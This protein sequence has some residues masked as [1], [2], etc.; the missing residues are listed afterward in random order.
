[1]TPG[2][3]CPWVVNVF[4]LSSLSDAWR[5]LGWGN[6]E[7]VRYMNERRSCHGKVYGTDELE[8]AGYFI[9]HGGL[10]AAIDSKADLLPLNPAYSDFFDE[11]Y[12]HQHYDGPR[13][14]TKVIK[15]VLMDLGKSLAS[16]EP[17]F[18]SKEGTVEERYRGVS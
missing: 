9:R 6:A 12:R 5:F 8:Y 18:V 3:P 15:P 11:L 7:F 17:V 2:L 13:P 4:D 14:S 10:Q 1:K 16:G